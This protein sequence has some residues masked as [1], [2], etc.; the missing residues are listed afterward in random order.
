MSSTIEAIDQDSQALS[1]V[2]STPQPVEADLHPERS[3]IPH[4]TPE[5]GGLGSP[6]FIGLLL[7]QFFTAFN[8]NMFRWL[9]VPI[10]QVMIGDTL[11]LALGAIFF[12]L[13]YLLLSP[14]AGYLADRF[15]KRNIVI[16]CKFAE[17]V[18]MLLGVLAISLGSI[19][20]LLILVFFMGAQSALFAPAKIG[21]IPETLAFKHLSNGN[22]IM[23]M[24]TIV[25]CALGM[26]AG[27]FLYDLMYE[28]SVLETG[29]RTQ[30]LIST[31]PA[32][33][34]LQ[35]V[36]IVGV[37]VSFMTKRTAAADVNRP[38]TINPL[39]ELVP[40]L[41]HLTRQPGLLNAALGIA[42]FYFI[43]LLYQVNVDQFGQDVLH[44]GSKSEVGLLMPFL[45]VGL[46]FGSVFAGLASAGR[47]QLGMVPIGAFLIAV[48]SALIAWYGLDF[49]ADYAQT[50]TQVQGAA[51]AEETLKS[52][53]NYGFRI[54]AGLLVLLGAVTGM[55]YI[56][57]EAYLQHKSPLSVRGSILAASNAIMNSFM[58][59]AMILFFLMREVAELS[60]SMVFFVAGLLTIPVAL[61]SFSILTRNTIRFIMWGWY[62]TFYNI[63]WH[64]IDR[65]PEEGGCLLA[66]N[67]ISWA[68]GA[69][70]AAMAPRHVRFMIYAN[71]TGK[72]YTRKLSEWMG[73]IPISPKDGPK[74]IMRSLKLA[75]EA[76]ENGEIVCIFPEGQLSRTGQMMPFQPGIERIVKKVDAPVLPLRLEGLWGSIFSYRRKLIWRLPDSFRSRIDIITGEPLHDKQTAPQIRRIIHEM[77][78]NHIMSH[79]E[80]YTVP[81]RKFIRQCRRSLFRSKVADSAGTDLSGAKLLIGTLAMKAKLEQII[82]KNEEMVGVLLPPSVGG[83]LA[84]TT[85]ACMKRVSVNLN[86]TLSDEVL[87]Y[88]VKEAGIKHVLTS[89]RFMEKKPMDVDAEL[90]YLEDIKEQI[91]SGDRM[92]AAF[93]AFTLPAFVLERMLGLHTIDPEETATIIFTSGS[94]GQPKGVMLSHRNLASNIDGADQLIKFKN[95]DVIIGILP[96]FH[97]FGYTISMWIPLNLPPKGV[98]HFNPLDARQV[99]KLCESHKGTILMATPT[100]LKSYMKRC[101]PEQFQ[102]LNLVVVGAEKL[103]ADLAAQFERKYGVLPMEGYGVTELSPGVAFNVPDHRNDKIDQTG[104]KPGTVGQPLPGVICHVVDPD[105]RED[106]GFNTEGLLIVKGPNV[107]K[108]YLNNPEKTAEAVQDGWYNTGDMAKIDEAG[109]ITIT[110]RI[111]RFSKIGGEMV[112]HLRVEEVLARIVDEL[113]P[114]SDE[115]QE[116]DPTAVLRI[117]VTSVSDE[118]KGERLIV[119]HKPL[120]CGIEPVVAK[121]RE[122][123]LPN[124]WLPDTGSF[125]QVDEIPLLGTGK[126]DLKA[127]KVLAEELVLAA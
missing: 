47:I 78:A 37:L 80:Q 14:F 81:V 51:D 108:G 22:G 85:L 2:S 112:P 93:K 3:N 23:G 109:F 33:I 127:I 120:G 61:Y 35:V 124:L 42:F 110:G 26:P 101:T 36:A 119:F 1:I 6:G 90:I 4:D 63:R 9:V 54:T 12:T 21:L 40:S 32:L 16:A 30:T 8:D 13:P 88:C 55:F 87:N 44:L 19:T 116:K 18:I 59:V 41:K 111:S 71:F 94:T 29:A 64:D 75:T 15:P 58:L 118:K 31:L 106:L 11:A 96:F 102:T 67:H 38:M 45:V 46:G 95:E 27:Y 84:N 50:I 68:D 43:A 79:P 115:V 92:T 121:L 62:T 125:V 25:A 123:G 103:Q 39:D 98:Y 122:S 69:M 48:S 34:G 57:L 10:G 56:P 91:S 99:G 70:L 100:F 74:A 60:P 24:V 7:V 107:M 83:V 117:A 28:T 77:G 82:G 97:S 53:S 86:Y 73:V 126:L 66:P 89:R 76:I 17:I 105:T 65:I 72:W 52:L 104:N 20:L 114:L 5:K 113:E 49:T